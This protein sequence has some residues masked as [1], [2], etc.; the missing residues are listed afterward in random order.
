M[1]CSPVLPLIND[2]EASLD[3]LAKAAAAAGAHAFGANVLFLKPCAKDVF[4]PFLEERFP[5][6]V[7]RYKERFD[8]QAYLTG[9][10]PDKIRE[11]V[12]GIRRRYGLEQD[13]E[14][15]QKEPEL[16]PQNAQMTL[17]V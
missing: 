9:D 15:P 14:G 6:L 13:R 7:R 10:Y 3:A 12:R 2:G 1:F 16:W 4:F 17:F 8:R 11:R 5:A